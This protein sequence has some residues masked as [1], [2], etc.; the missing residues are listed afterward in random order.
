MGAHT[1]AAAAA[2][3]HIPLIDGGGDI[4]VTEALD[5]QAVLITASEGHIAPWRNLLCVQNGHVNPQTW[6]EGTSLRAFG[7]MEPHSC[8]L[9][10]H[11]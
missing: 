4:S 8:H 3:L 10:L 6:N 11:S 2:A 5:F 9:I 7:V 1:P